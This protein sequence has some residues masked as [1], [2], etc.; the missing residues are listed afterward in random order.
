VNNNILS[1]ISAII[2]LGSFSC[3]Q[4]DAPARVAEQAGPKRNPYLASDVAAITHYNPAQTDAV[5]FGVKAGEFRVDLA[6]MPHSLAGPVNIMCMAAA[7]TNYMWVNSTDRVAYIDVRNN[8]WKEI[9]SLPLKGIARREVAAVLNVVFNSVAQVDSLARKAYGESP[10]DVLTSG[11]YVLVD[12]ENII[13]INSGTNIVAYGLKDPAHPETG[14]EVKREIDC[15]SFM[16]A[17]AI[18]GFPPMVKLIGVGLTYD[19]FLIIGGFNAIAI[20]DR[21]FKM[22]PIVYTMEPDQLISNSV[23]VDDQNGIYVV[24]GNLKP[25]GNGIIR[26]LVWKDGRISDQEKDGAWQSPYEGGDYPPAVKFGTGTGST[27]SLLGFATGEDK[28]VVITDGRNRMNLV[29]FW[30]D[31]IPRDAKANPA[32]ISPRIADQWSI[33]AGL[34]DSAQWIQSEQ[35]VVVGNGGAFVVNNMVADAPKDKL[36]DVLCSGKLVTPPMGMEKVNWNNATHRWEKGWTNVNVNSTSMVPLLSTGSNMVFVNGYTKNDGWEVNGLDWQTGQVKHR[37]IF[38]HY[39]YGN[40]AYALMQFASNGD[41]LF[42]S[43]GGP[44]RIALK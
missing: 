15:A 17:I 23:C 5:P 14:I 16:P 2:F 4:S 40:G 25:R 44:F 18:P 41:M 7:D 8:G 43:V 10:Q 9:A 42:N 32:F 34:P 11:L 22:T 35:S 20:I 19:G 6:A 37:T 12:N 1:F 21:Q 38:G 26:K 39:N 28:L 3:S 30:R 29:A 36:V 13:Y 27:A 24:S 33:S 31:E